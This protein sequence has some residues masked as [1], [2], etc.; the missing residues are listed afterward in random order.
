M[1]DQRPGPSGWVSLSFLNPGNLNFSSQK[2]NNFLRRERT[3][4]TDTWHAGCQEGK[5]GSQF[6]QGCEEGGFGPKCPTFWVLPRVLTHLGHPPIGSCVLSANCSCST[7]CRAVRCWATQGAWVG[8]AKTGLTN[9]I[10]L[11]HIHVYFWEELGAWSQKTLIS[12]RY[13][14][15][16][17]LLAALTG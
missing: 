11:K 5:G 12:V 8:K 10:S 15:L 4:L 2:W 7:L 13:H 1:R 14:I 6:S 16:R 3:S 17:V 9:L